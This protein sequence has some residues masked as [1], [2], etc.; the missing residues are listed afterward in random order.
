MG[1][2]K[3]LLLLHLVL[4]LIDI[5]EHFLKVFPICLWVFSHCVNFWGYQLVYLGS[6]LLGVGFSVQ[7]TAKS[8]SSEGLFAVDVKMFGRLK[9]LKPVLLQ[10]GSCSSRCGASWHPLLVALAS[11]VTT[12][13]NSWS[14]CHESLL[15]SVLLAL[16]LVEPIHRRQLRD[17]T[18]RML[19]LHEVRRTH[20]GSLLVAWSDIFRISE[21]LRELLLEVEGA[22]ALWLKRLLE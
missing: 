17:S 1:A 9:G 22:N 16:D 10:E 2:K 21:H 5:L 18:K 12:N 13:E 19:R 15:E 4:L 11:N 14:S 3:A 7:F 8:V 6:R 20:Q